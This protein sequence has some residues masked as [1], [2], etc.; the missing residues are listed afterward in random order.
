MLRQI[1]YSSILFI[2]LFTSSNYSQW[3]WQNPLPQGNNLSDIYV[4]DE[5]KAIAVGAIGTVIKT[6]DGGTSWNS[7]TSGTTVLLESVHFTDNNTG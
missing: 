5:N 1:I 3:F 6:T 4:F 7:Q 2:F